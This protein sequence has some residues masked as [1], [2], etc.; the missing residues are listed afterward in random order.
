MSDLLY[1]F[2]LLLVVQAGKFLATR[3]LHLRSW[4]PCTQK[5]EWLQHQTISDELSVLF[6]ELLEP[7][8]CLMVVWQN[9]WSPK[10][11]NFKSFDSL[12][13]ARHSMEYFVPDP[14]ISG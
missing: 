4:L 3:H 14:S 9:K 2:L 13:N 1:S 8:G 5:V 7:F 10:E 11:I 12:N 6:F